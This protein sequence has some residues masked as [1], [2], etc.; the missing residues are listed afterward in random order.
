[1]IQ[2][3]LRLSPLTDGLSWLVRVWGLDNVSGRDRRHGQESLYV[4]GL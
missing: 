1:M 4:A 3:G 2:T